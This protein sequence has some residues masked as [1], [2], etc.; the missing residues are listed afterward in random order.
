MTVNTPKIRQF[1]YSQNG[2]DY[3]K[4]T[5][6]LTQDE[7]L[8]FDYPIVYIV[9]DENKTSSKYQKSTFDVYVGEANWLEQR[10]RQHLND[11]ND[12]LQ[13]LTH[14]PR[15][16]AIG[17]DMFTKSMTLDI[18]NRLIN[19]MMGIDRVKSLNGRG[20]QQGQYYTSNMTDEIFHKIWNKLHNENK[21]LIPPLNVVRDSALFKAS[22]FHKLSEKQRKAKNE[23]IS[24]IESALSTE[25]DG[26]LIIIDG[27][28]GTG[29]TVLLSSLFFELSSHGQGE[30]ANPI[31]NNLDSY[32][33][34]NHDEQLTV[35]DQIAKKLGLS[36][37]NHDIVKKPTT[38][39]NHRSVN[40]KADVVLVD[41]A[42]LL[43][44][45]GKQSWKSGWQ[46]DEIRKRAKVTVIVFDQ[47]QI[48][49]SEQH[50]DSEHIA[51][52]FLSAN[53]VVKLEDQFRIDASD[54][55]IKW[56][57]NFV[58]GSID[59]IPYDNKYD[60]KIFEDP[61]KMYHEIV[62]KSKDKQNG[63]SRMLATFD[64]EYKQGKSGYGKNDKWTVIADNLELPWNLETRTAKDKQRNRGLSWAESDYS[65][66]E[67]GSTFTIQGFD[68]N[69][70]G[71]ILGPSVIYRDGK[72][73]FDPSASANK[74]AIKKRNGKDHAVEHL[75]NELNVLIKRGVHGL[76]LYAVDSELQKALL[77]AQNK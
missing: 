41:E 32:L 8:F 63:L 20:N 57:E 76:F 9:E 77:D 27:A 34:V 11:K 73:S 40:S 53:C 45:Q 14:N 58:E 33:L 13:K 37:K 5:L 64:W 59:A 47:K 36:T 65:I 39:I 62:H 24:R 68:L 6:S 42:H 52:M 72:V 19:N 44:T 54:E 12:K 35:Y 7:K 18:E 29:K 70:A 21:E 48:L 1:E 43:W 71:L 60:L 56:I 30:F 4:H 15:V 61:L 17:H 55:T 16:Y 2:L 28:A 23:I 51:T 74:N 25:D 22:P 10:T 75:K 66:N 69:Y 67:I 31:I 3:L 49:R 50:I 38:W 26:Q 46:L